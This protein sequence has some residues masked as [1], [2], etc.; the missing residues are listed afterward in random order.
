[1][2]DSWF[3]RKKS[4][5]IVFLAFF[6]YMRFNIELIP[7]ITMRKESEIRRFYS[8]DIRIRGF[9]PGL[10]EGE[11]AHPRLNLTDGHKYFAEDNLF[12]QGVH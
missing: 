9:R 2:P 12:I 10:W 3:E 11:P 1:M 8:V 6:Y 7:I 4:K 5:E